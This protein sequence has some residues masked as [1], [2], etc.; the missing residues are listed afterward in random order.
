[1]KT[2]ISLIVLLCGSLCVNATEVVRKGPDLTS[3]TVLTIKS[4]NPNYWSAGDAERTK[5]L[6]EATVPVSIALHVLALQVTVRNPT[7]ADRIRSWVSA[8]SGK[9]LSTLFIVSPS[10]DLLVIQA[11]IVQ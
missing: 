4:V 8:A 2:I 11:A 5:Q 3:R 1:M 9:R 6:V 7:Q 10:S